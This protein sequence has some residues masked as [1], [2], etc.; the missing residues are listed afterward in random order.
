MA[1]NIEDVPSVEL[2]TELLR[3]A[4]CSS[5]PDKRIILVGKTRSFPYP[6]RLFLPLVRFLA[7]SRGKSDLCSAYLELFILP[8]WGVE[9]GALKFT[10]VELVVV[11]FTGRLVLTALFCV[12]T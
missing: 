10:M 8:M 11:F 6:L 9:L 12:A 4:K 3:R 2:M 5:K 1:T 7:Q